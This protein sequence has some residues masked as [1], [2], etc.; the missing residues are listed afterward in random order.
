MLRVGTY[1]SIASNIYSPFFG[2]KLNDLKSLILSNDTQKLTNAFNAKELDAIIVDS[3][4]V[5]ELSG[6]LK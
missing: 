3:E 4:F 5:K 1:D 2:K 6:R